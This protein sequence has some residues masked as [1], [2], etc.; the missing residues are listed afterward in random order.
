MKMPVVRRQGHQPV[1]G[2]QGRARLGRRTASLIRRLAPGDLAVI[3][4]LD[5]DQAS[6]Q[7]LVDAKVAAVLNVA[8]STSGRYPNRGPQVLVDAGVVLV[9][10]PDA[11]LFSR[12]TDGDEVLLDHGV[13]YR[14]GVEIARGS[15]LD[16]ADV[17]ASA[18]SARAGM[19]AQLEAFSANAMEFIR[20]DGDLLLEGVGVPSLRTQIAG[21]PVVVVAK[22]F[23]HERDLRALRTFIR[24]RK[25]VLVGVD[26][27]AEVLRSAGHRPHLIVGDIDT[28]GDRTLRCGA[29]IVVRAPR[30]GLPAGLDRLER[31]G[32]SATVFRTSVTA[33]DAAM[34]L[35]DSAGADFIVSVGGPGGLE[36][37]LD[38]GRSGMTSSFLTRLRLGPRL[39]DAK[40]VQRLH[41]PRV[42]TWQL[43]LLALL[44]LLAVGAALLTT[45]T[46]E[47][48]GRDLFAVLV[49][50]WEAAQGWF[51]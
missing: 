6:A 33:E 11:E 47:A 30:D 16:R 28:M 32:V 39:L 21:R 13:V 51:A 19:A 23:D 17:F 45:P 27:G 29:E 2:L 7:A 15:V 31:L 4:H 25:P 35:A 37:Y 24:E 44:G 49:Q 48:W 18:E 8:P 50:W 1:S 26:A 42:A 3:D 46:G 10:L 34:L 9:D 36:E 40:A 22:N 5:L 12:L 20:R 38:R 14:K 41:Q 43:L